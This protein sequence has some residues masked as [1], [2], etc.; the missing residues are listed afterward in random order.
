MSFLLLLLFWR[1]S[2]SRLLVFACFPTCYFFCFLFLF[3]FL[4]PLLVN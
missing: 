1:H 3:F 2:D 4:M